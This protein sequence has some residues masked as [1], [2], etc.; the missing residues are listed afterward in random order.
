MTQTNEVSRPRC[1]DSA[2][3]GQCDSQTS[4]SDSHVAAESGCKTEAWDAQGWLVAL[5]QILE[6]TSYV[7]SYVAKWYWIS[8][9]I[10]KSIAA[11]QPISVKMA[12]I[13][14]LCILT[15]AYFSSYNAAL[16]D[17]VIAWQPCR[18]RTGFAYQQEVSRYHNA[19]TKARVHC[20]VQH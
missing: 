11:A 17:N 16:Q 14:N 8:L 20:D 1:C 4:R 9:E 19:K 13:S 10:P 12:S 3:D 2:R 7:M 18:I 15:T 6:G 5:S